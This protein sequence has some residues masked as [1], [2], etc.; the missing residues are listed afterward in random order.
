M[1]S[2]NKV[3]HAVPCVTF[4]FSLKYFA[5]DETVVKD[6]FTK[7]NEQ[8]CYLDFLSIA[9]K[10]HLCKIY[11]VTVDVPNARYDIV[12]PNKTSYSIDV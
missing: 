4:V 7:D 9:L 12:N 5:K 8:I 10:N 11:N 3:H 1:K 2:V 6:M